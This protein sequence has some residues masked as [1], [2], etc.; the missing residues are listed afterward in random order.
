MSKNKN[1]LSKMRLNT[2]ET[3]KYIERTKKHSRKEKMRTSIT[4]SKESRVI[5]HTYHCVILPD[6]PPYYVENVEDPEEM[7]EAFDWWAENTVNFLNEVQ[8]MYVFTTSNNDEWRALMKQAETNITSGYPKNT[9]FLWKET[10][11]SEAEVY[12]VDTYVNFLL[13]WC[14]QQIEN[15]ELFPATEDDEYTPDF[16]KHMSKMFKRMFR[17]FQI[18]YS[19]DCLRKEISQTSKHVLKHFL[20]FGWKWDLLKD[21]DT[22]MLAEFTGQIKDKFL[23]DEKM[24]MDKKLPLK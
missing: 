3:M 18:I 9:T 8:M 21:K 16:A 24:Y 20:Y 6:K 2:S 23:R 10:P 4:D 13:D 11:T 14:Q 22:S 12:T 17:I 5:K 15:P 7:Y 19:N 1:N